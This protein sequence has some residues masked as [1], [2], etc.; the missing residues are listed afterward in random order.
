MFFIF[1]V[2]FSFIC[3]LVPATIKKSDS[4]LINW[5]FQINDGWDNISIG[6]PDNFVTCSEPNNIINLFKEENEAAS[7]VCDG[8]TWHVGICVVG[9]MSI[10]VG[11]SGDCQCTTDTVW[12]VRPAINNRNWGGVGKECA[13]PSQTLTVFF[14]K[15]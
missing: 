14:E 5:I 2:I 11:S 7:Y 8:R 4:R 13:A 12:T 3:I 10:A 6:N 9:R 1:I 15:D